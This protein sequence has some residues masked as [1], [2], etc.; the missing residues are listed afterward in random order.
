MSDMVIRITLDAA[1]LKKELGLTEEQIKKVDGTQID[2]KTD[3]AQSGIAKLRDG[4]AMWSLALNGAIKAAKGLA[5]AVNSVVAPAMEQEKAALDLAAALKNTGVYSAQLESRLLAQAS[6][7]QAV[8][9]YGDDAIIMATRQMQVIGQLSSDQL[10]AAQKAAVGLASA[11]KLDLTTAFEMVGKAAAGNTATLS[12]YGI[13]LDEGLA[14]N[15][16]FNELLR[17][18]AERFELAR[19]EANTTAGALAQMNNLWGDLKEVIGT[20][21]LPLLG[22]VSTAFADVLKWI[23]GISNN[24]K[25]AE[26]SAADLASQFEFLTGKVLEYKGQTTLTAQEQEEFNGFIHELKQ[27]FPEYFDGMDIMAMK[28]AD[29]ATAISNARNEIELLMDRMVLQAVM[30]DYSDDLIKVGKKIRTAQEELQ[31]YQKM[32]AEG[33][34]WVVVGPDMIRSVKMYINK[35]NDEIERFRK[36]K[37]EIIAERD[38]VAKELSVLPEPPKPQTPKKPKASG[39]GT[40]S[41]SGTGTGTPAIVTSEISETAKAYEHLLQ[42]LQKYHDERALAGLSAHQ[43]HLAELSAQFDAEQQIVLDALAAQ[44]ISEEEASIRLADIRARFDAEAQSTK[45]AADNEL[46]RLSRERLDRSVQ[47]EEAYY[48]T[49]R[50]ADGDYYEWKVEQIRKEV[51]AMAIGDEAKMALIQQHLA[52]LD[53]LKEEYSSTDPE[54]KSNW[55][56]NGLL[57][58][59]PDNEEDIAKVQAIRDTYQSLASQAQS[60]TGGLMNL[61]RQRKDQEIADLEARAAKE[62]MTNDQLIKQKEAITK[63]YEAEERKLKKIQKAM[64][65]SQAIIS[66][67]EGAAKAL[68]MGPIIGPIMAAFITALG[69]AQVGIIKAQKFAFGGIVRG[70]GGPKDDKIPAMLSNGEYII[71][72][73]A[74]ERYRPLLD[75]INFGRSV[76]V[77]PK[78][79][80]ADGGVVSGGTDFGKKLDTL[81]N[82]VNVLN[83]N[84]VKKDMKPVLNISG[85]VRDMLRVQ[86]KSRVRMED[87]G[88]DPNYA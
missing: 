44:E 35:Y 25:Q 48:E 19:E 46:I 5:S 50:F 70:P 52:E 87:L 13:V 66:T 31:K 49:M 43:K 76:S 55:F 8:T 7:I 82:Q 18:G 60:I 27:E 40:G 4:L 12:R 30:D 39:A 62:G 22:D 41:G 42:Q 28:Y 67:A 10:P 21:I 65:I 26:K 17:I 80:Y 68:A 79:A 81:I 83:M 78:L 74:T 84:L 53:A 37:A 6:A 3:S 69:L 23:Q 85:S 20:W 33:D 29:V 45:I 9:T 63:K 16:K 86:D 38:A 54:T 34:E 11:Y 72:A 36:K 71:R 51:E 32:Q 57:G 73:E 59:D 58:F 24:Q 88:Y 75:A 14:P 56:F 64:S 77:Q 47:D 61:S 2:V 1:Q 15:E